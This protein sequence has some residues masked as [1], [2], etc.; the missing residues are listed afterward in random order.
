MGST[1]EGDLELQN[2]QNTIINAYGDD[3]KSKFVIG[4]ELTKV[5]MITKY[6]SSSK[7]AKKGNT[8]YDLFVDTLPF[9]KVVATKYIAI[10]STKFLKDLADNPKTVQ[11][12]PSGYNNLFA[13]TKKEIVENEEMVTK[14]TKLF[15]K[16]KTK[17]GKNTNLSSA[18]KLLDEISGKSET[19][20]LVNTLATLKIKEGAIKSK[21]EYESMAETY[22]NFLKVKSLITQLKEEVLK[23][24]FIT[25][26]CDLDKFETASKKIS[27]ENTKLYGTSKQTNLVSKITKEAA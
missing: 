15:T 21:G 4:D 17:D 9:G 20:E 27:D 24:D 25:L 11:N 1:Y 7:E 13:Y 2:I 22:S 18:Q 3:V 19:K 12:L 16:G 10:A 6:D 26:E 5:K 8:K 14:L 23:Y